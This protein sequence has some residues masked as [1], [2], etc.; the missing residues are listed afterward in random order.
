MLF[1]TKI[2]ISAN[3]VRP[4]RLPPARPDDEQCNAQYQGDDDENGHDGEVLSGRAEDPQE[5]FRLL[6]K[7]AFETARDSSRNREESWRTTPAQ[8]F[9]QSE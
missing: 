7:E 8:L 5:S 9:R 2:G 6:V 4:R 3:V 1:L